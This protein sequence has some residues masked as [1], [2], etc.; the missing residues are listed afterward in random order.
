MILF[1]LEFLIFLLI[2][3]T[4]PFFGYLAVQLTH[5]KSSENCF[6]IFANQLILKDKFP[7]ILDFHKKQ[8]TKLYL[9][10]GFIFVAIILSGWWVL[11][12]FLVAVK[13][14]NIY[15]ITIPIVS[16]VIYSIISFVLCKK[17]KKQISQLGV[18][19]RTHALEIF[20]KYQNEYVQ[21]LDVSSV[22]IC[23]FF[24][25][26][27]IAGFSIN[28]A[29]RFTQKR[30]QKKLK[31]LKRKIKNGHDQYQ[32]LKI[33]INY[34]KSF[35]SFLLG[36]EQNSESYSYFVVLDWKN[37]ETFSNSVVIDGQRYENFEVLKEVLISNFF[38]F[39][40]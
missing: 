15:F 22:K 3:V 20:T 26:D 6:K 34:L 23:Q 2:T 12:D 10:Y 14:S 40:N 21:S 35:S 18:Y 1:I 8:C 36:I 5:V 33:Y 39:A 31:R 13:S 32:L 24:R 11:F 30:Y 7:L 25:N 4:C 19:D 27:Q 17:N 16:I 9:I 28:G 38:A 37:N 29:F